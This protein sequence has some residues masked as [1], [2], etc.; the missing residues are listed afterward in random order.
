MPVAAAIG[1]AGLAGAGA[2]IY[3]AQT[4][5][6]AATTQGGK[7][8]SAQNRIYEQNAVAAQPFI[9]GGA[10]AMQG[11]NA[12]LPGL[13]TPFNPSMSWLQQFPGYQFALQQGLGA[14]QSSSIASGASGNAITGAANYAEGLASTTEAQAAQQYYTGKQT[15]I[16][17]YQAAVQPG[18][19]AVG[20]QFGAGASTGQGIAS[21]YSGIGQAQAGAAMASGNALSS[22][23]QTAGGAYAL[24]YILGAMTQ[25]T[26]GASNSYIPS[27]QTQT[28]YGGG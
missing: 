17:A 16:G 23:I 2:S 5:A 10:Q 6:G 26:G 11:F 28:T 22:G 8:I 27:W 18:V 21:S 19:S 25:G 14:V 7:A 24:P 20:A 9:Q 1:I 3:G 13:T 4:A 15:A 12:A